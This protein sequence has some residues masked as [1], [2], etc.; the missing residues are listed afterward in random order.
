MLTALERAIVAVADLESAAGDYRRLLGREPCYERESAEPS[1]SAVFRLANTCLELRTQVAGTSLAGSDASQPLG[2]CALEFATDDMAAC[3]DWLRGRGIELVGA[4]EGES[5]DEQGG[6]TWRWQRASIPARLSRG[7]AIGIVC[8]DPESEAPASARCVGSREAVH[9]LD[10]VVISTGDAEAARSFYRDGLG[11]RLALDRSFEQRGL[12]MLFFRVGGV[13]VE[14]VA[15]LDSE[16]S[17]DPTSSAETAPDRFGGLAWR[18]EDLKAIHA[19]LGR[20]GVDVSEHRVGHKP[21]TR[22]CTLRDRTH[23]VPTLL[24]GDDLG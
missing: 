24:I 8:V 9:A 22:V 20:D 5:S 12:R 15:A 14:V 1:R 3:A 17:R 6:A 21:G 19:R 4:R 23:A 2:L 10:H 11:L 18:V 16:P 7:I 13:T